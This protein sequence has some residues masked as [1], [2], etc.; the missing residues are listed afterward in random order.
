LHNLHLIFKLTC[1]S[2]GLYKHEIITEQI[3]RA[4]P[5]SIHTHKYC[6]FTVQ[7]RRKKKRVQKAK[8]AT[9]MMSR[10]IANP[11][12]INVINQCRYRLLSFT[13]RKLRE[14]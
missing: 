1:I 6:K 11:K 4:T 3:I 5:N 8:I 2:L 14:S 10:T 12:S 13:L 9:I 7:F